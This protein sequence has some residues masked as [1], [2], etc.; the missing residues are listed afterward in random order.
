VV[1]N[2]IVYNALISACGSGKQS[3]QALEVCEAMHRQCVV[4]NTITNSALISA[5]EKDKQAVHAPDVLHALEVLSTRWQQG[6]LHC[7]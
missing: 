7:L 6:A 5:C 2:A 3:E 4:P 1:P